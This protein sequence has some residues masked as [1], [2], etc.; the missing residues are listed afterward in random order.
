LREPHL[1]M[2]SDPEDDGIVSMVRQT[3]SVPITCMLGTPSLYT[4]RTLAVFL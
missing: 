3:Q 2:A 1:R 4:M